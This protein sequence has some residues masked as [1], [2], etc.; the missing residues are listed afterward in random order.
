M[1]APINVLAFTRDI[2]AGEQ[3]LV[4][5]STKKQLMLP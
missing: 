3:M 2:I 4:S 1:A 5:K